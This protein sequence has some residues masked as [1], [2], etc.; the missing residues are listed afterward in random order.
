ML[1]NV[2]PVTKTI[3]FNLIP[4]ENTKRTIVRNG[5]I[6]E[7][8]QLD[9]DYN[10]LKAAADRVHKRF[11]EET[12]SS[13]SARL[14]YLSDG[15]ADSIQEY[16]EAFYAGANVKEL[17]AIAKRLKEAVQKAFDGIGY[18][19]SMNYRKALMSEKLFKEI[20]PEE[21]L[22]DEEKS[23]LGRM[24]KHTTYMRPYFT[25]RNRM[26]GAGEKGF[27]I[28]IR[29]IDENL[30]IHLKN[31][32]FFEN[33]P[34]EEQ[35]KIRPAYQMVSEHLPFTF[36]LPDVFT[37]S[38]ASCLL[39]QSA[40][41]AYNT[42]I[43]GYTLED[44]T[45]IQGVN[46]II[47]L[48]NQANSK[49]KDFHKLPKLK[50]LKKQILSDRESFSWLPEHFTEDAE[51]LNAITG[52]NDEFSRI[53]PLDAIPSA[54]NKVDTSGILVDVD[55][56]SEYSH[57]ICGRWNEAE[58]AIKEK[59]RKERP[60][61][62]RQTPER[63][64]EAINKL[65]KSYGVY[66]IEAIEDAVREHE[67]EAG[68]T[69]KGFAAYV[70]E[71][72]GTP[73]A[74]AATHY[75]DVVKRIDS[76]GPDVKLGQTR[77]DGNDNIRTSIK[78]W[79]D[80]LQDACRGAALFTEGNGTQTIDADF[81][82]SVIA[83]LDGFRDML[84]PVYNKIRNYLTRKPFSTEKLR[85]FFGSAKLLNG[86]DRNKDEDNR[87]ILLRDGARKY[88]AILAPQATTLFNDERA[89]DDASSLQ[90][91]S[92]KYIPGASKQLSHVGFCPGGRSKYQPS[93]KLE[94]LYDSRK[95]KSDYTVEEIAMMI[96][97]YK[98]VLATYHEWASLDFR[99]KETKEYGS[100]NEFFDD[101]DR[102]AYFISWKGVSRPFFERAIERGDIYLF[103][104]DSRD[105]HEGHHGVDD[106]YKA[107]LDEAFSDRNVRET[108]FRISGGAA[109]YF[110]EASLPRI[111]THPKNTLLRNKN[112]RSKYQVR[113][114]SYDLIKD[115]RYT[116]DR[117][118]L[119]LPVLVG[120][121]N[122]KNGQGKIN[123][124]VK[125]IIRKNPDMYVLGINRGER[126]LLSIAVTDANGR[127]V[128]QK[129]LNIFD[130]VDYR[131]KLAATETARD[132]SRKDWNSIDAIKNLK[133]GYLSRAIGEIV[134]LVKKYNCMVALENLDME[135]KRGRQKFEKNVYVEFERALVG[136]LSFLMDKNDPDRTRTIQQLAYPGKTVGERT[137]YPQC[138][139]VLFLS[140]SFIT[141]TDPITGFANRLNTHYKSVEDAERIIGS[142]DSLR[143]LPEEGMF[144][145]E[146]R[147]S[148]TSP[149]KGTSNDKLWKIYTHG[150]R[151]KPVK[152]EKDVKGEPRMEVVDA[153]E[154]MRQVF[155]NEGIDFEDGRELLPCMTGRSAA[156]YKGFLDAL[157]LTLK[158]TIW[159]GENSMIVSCTKDVDG[160]FFDEAYGQDES[161]PKDADANAARNIARKAL[162]VMRNI[163]TFVP[164][165]TVDSDGKKLKE[166]CMVVSDKEWFD[167][168]QNQ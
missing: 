135:F 163:R 150:K 67:E 26:Y 21:T 149:E 30:P 98:K 57:V 12:L 60:I 76:D 156:F 86:W 123:G 42:L 65:F 93:E 71:K 70:V 166:P 23:A 24:K 13:P 97:Y 115:R 120:P 103:M 43:G 74:D 79:L 164:G 83:P 119:H 160:K 109:I 50:K 36:E 5:V 139:I 111:I 48:Y 125:D 80:D 140:P 153:T 34:E 75:S 158:N 56:L 131:E 55:K 41:D 159:D 37:V 107:I 105:M 68:M 66:S 72:I 148:R 29:I 138:G 106:N 45:K 124:L 87:G 161:A 61:G 33:I 116:E 62:A 51:V 167:Y 64:N 19:D 99:L 8:R 101:I 88:L 142:Y 151:N 91:M 112:P 102:Q 81:Y 35:K 89:Y 126:N 154:E 146:F 90:R 147:Y 73:L 31:V 22:T 63:Y 10:V 95:N 121:E 28:P 92:L 137:R 122:D 3:A 96:D 141:M 129:H 77:E 38:A 100:V 20:L 52:L 7:A 6:E 53:N 117:F 85:L 165:K 145:L 104:I 157:R 130:N 162:I 25:I 128:E 9:Q 118:M 44:G 14:K 46:E 54:I 134:R 94:S 114:L 39:A 127:I 84:V 78:Q 15:G 82:E 17:G 32:K 168:A 58:E 59:L 40:I 133:K 1:S 4:D 69:L 11:I 144:R 27:T 143:Y 136:R 113:T 110:R 47:N 155:I 2:F 16:A 108:K 49:N 132:Q 152:T 18:D